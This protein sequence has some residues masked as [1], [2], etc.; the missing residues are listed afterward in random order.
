MNDSVTSTSIYSDIRAILQSARNKAYTAVNTA[1]I[2]AYWLIGKRVEDEKGYTL[3]S[4]L[5]WSHIRLIMRID[6]PQARTYYLTESKAT[7]WS[8]RQLERHIQSRYYERLLSSAEETNEPAASK[9]TEQTTPKD[10]VKDPYVL[11]LLNKLIGAALVIEQMEELGK[12]TVPW[13]M[14]LVAKKPG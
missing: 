14:A 10:F 13:L 3:C 5:S 4:F 6:N 11:E 8:V 7:N 12:G 1:M 2:E 9:P